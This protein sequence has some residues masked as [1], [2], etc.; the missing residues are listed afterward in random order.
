MKKRYLFL[1]CI[2]FWISIYVS[3]VHGDEVYNVCKKSIY[4]TEQLLIQYKTSPI[5]LKYLLQEEIEK[6]PSEMKKFI[7][8]P[9]HYSDKEKKKIFKKYPD[10]IFYGL[11]LASFMENSH[12]E[13]TLRN[14]PDIKKFFK[15]Q[16]SRRNIMSV[17]F[18]TCM[19]ITK[20]AFCVKSSNEKC[21]QE[22]NEELRDWGNINFQ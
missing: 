5:P 10:L 12:N 17:L 20:G 9:D 8:S 1:T 14:D 6:M 19:L 7:K 22:L 15:D 11:M 4:K 3:T 16:E 13:V 18:K 21:K 2:I